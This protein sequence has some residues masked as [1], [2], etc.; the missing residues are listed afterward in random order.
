MTMP[1]PALFVAATLAIAAPAPRLAA[2][3]EPAWGK[4][5][6]AMRLG[7]HT[8]K[9][10]GGEA[11]LMAVIEN[12]GDDDLI[13]R[14]GIMLANGKKQLPTAVRL[15]LTGGDG[16]SRTLVR[17]VGV[18]AGRVEPFIV[19]LAAGCRYSVSCDLGQFVPMDAP[20]MPPTPGRYKMAAEFVGESVTGKV[21]GDSGPGLMSYWTGTIRSADVQVTVP[22]VPAK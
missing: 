3:E 4:P 20:G 10:K 9:A 19:P 11:R 1:S 18:I 5:I 12:V 17:K 15:T 14:L 2:P 8:M 7:L 16:K 21:N 13:V 6:K 22:A